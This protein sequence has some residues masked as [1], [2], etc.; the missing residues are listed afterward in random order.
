MNKPRKIARK[1]V[2]GTDTFQAC[3]ELRP[4]FVPQWSTLNRTQLRAAC[5]RNGIVFGQM[6]TADMIAALTA[7]ARP[8][9]V[10]PKV[11]V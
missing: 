4:T 11:G 3:R 6:R 10:R 1:F 2:Q 7:V 8:T 5:K 9:V